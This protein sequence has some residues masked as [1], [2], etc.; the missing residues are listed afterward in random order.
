MKT[1]ANA[2]P[3]Q[4]FESPVR[5]A[6]GTA[7]AAEVAQSSPFQS[8]SRRTAAAAKQGSTSS[9]RT[10]KSKQVTVEFGKP[11]KNLFVRVHPSPAYSRLGLAV[12]HDEFNGKFHF[13][14]PALY[15]SGELPERFRNACRIMDVYT[16]GVADGSFFIWH[17]FESSSPWY[18]A[19]NKVVDLARRGYGIVAS[20][21]RTQSYSFEP[22]EEPIPEP[23]WATLAP[24]E[25]LLLEAFDSIVSV[26]G[27]KVVLDFMSGGAAQR[28]GDEGEA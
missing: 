13:I 25:Q 24:F 12:Y 22:A 28:P 17:V 10:G 15:E 20:M 3:E 1:A 7:T 4:D 5:P 27:D 6:N 8:V 16:A 21:K 14:S 11:P 2:V 26:P 19:A 18:K 23:E 9:S